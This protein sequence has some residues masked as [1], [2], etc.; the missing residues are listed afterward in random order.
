VST[1]LALEPQV[2]SALVTGGVTLTVALLGLF[3]ELLRRQNKKLNKVGDHAEAARD[4]V[5]NSHKTNL[6]DDLD[7]VIEGL[8]DVKALLRSQGKDI[9]GMR[10]EIRHERVERVYVEKRLDDHLRLHQ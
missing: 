9:S 5:Q 1:I 8:A 10:E 3:A 2:Q 7:K 4:Q 6:R